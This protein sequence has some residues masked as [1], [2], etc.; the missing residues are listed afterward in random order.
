MSVDR[1]HTLAGAARVEGIGLHGGGDCAVVLRPAAADTGRGFLVEGIRVPAEVAYVVDTRLAT[2][3]GHEGATVTLVE[4]LCA[5]LHAR[6]VDNVEIE[7]HG[8][9]VPALD[10]SAR[11][12]L[13]RIDAV[14]LC[15][16]A[17]PR[18]PLRVDREVRVGDASAWIALSPSPDDA[19]WLDVSVEFAHPRIGAQ[20][21]AGPLSAFS[22]HL[23]WARTFGFFRDA[24]RL[25]AAGLA[26]GASLDN[27]V[28]FDDTDVLN[29]GGLR[30][31]DEVVRHKA[32]DAVGDL[33]LL[34]RPVAGRL[35][36]H[37]A[38]HALHLQLVRALAARS[39][40]GAR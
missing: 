21:Y 7:V 27:T 37:R 17:A 15:A 16:Q 2:T 22:E 8:G 31:P 12:W 39:P 1:Q 10:G 33:A 36:A 9:E 13:A 19:L 24:E 28:V 30:A 5:A 6:G 40:D 32:L 23:A 4:H 34:G 35:T 25:R 20:R 18:R 14:G 11:E 38:G 29:D 3:L 26:R